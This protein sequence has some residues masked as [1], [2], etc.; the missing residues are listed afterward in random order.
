MCSFLALGFSKKSLRG[1]EVKV[2]VIDSAG[3]ST[4]GALVLPCHF[5][6]FI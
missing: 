5:A 3:L 4:E 1:K 6:F 2:R